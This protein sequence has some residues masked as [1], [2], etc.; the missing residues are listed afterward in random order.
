MHKWSFL[1]C[2]SV[3]L[4]ACSACMRS[5]PST[6]EKA[7]IDRT[8]ILEYSD[9]LRDHDGKRI[10]HV[11]GVLFSVYEQ[12]EG[13]APVWMEVQNVTPDGRGHFT[14]Q[15]GSTKSEGIPPEL[16]GDEKTRWLGMQV[17]LPGETEQPRI[18]LVKGSKGLRTTR[19]VVPPENIV[20]GPVFQEKSWSDVQSAQ[21]HSGDPQQGQGDPSSSPDARRRN[22]HRFPGSPTP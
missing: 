5:D 20:P 1:V 21:Q 17:L 8:K 12:Q 14:A 15:V 2:V 11:A 9:V 19:L 6:P 22:R 10:T 3:T 13:G 18:R 4:L 16:F 7:D